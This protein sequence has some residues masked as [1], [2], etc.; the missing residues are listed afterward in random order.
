MKP[1][2]IADV[3][4]FANYAGTM[5]WT[6]GARQRSTIAD[7]AQWLAERAPPLGLSKYSEAAVVLSYAPAPALALGEL[8]D[9]NS[10]T[11]V[12]DLGAGAGGLG[13]TLAILEPSWRVVLADR[14]STAAHFLSLTAQRLSIDNVQVVEAEAHRL[15]RQEGTVYDLVCLRALAAAEI[16][17]GLA[18]PLTRTSGHIAAWHQAK[19]EGFYGPPGEVQRL[20]TAQTVVEGL[21]VSLLRPT[22]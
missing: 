3:E 22:G 11:D 8:I 16:A 20:D 19:D 17:L 5:G 15:A 6:I 13:L 9:R 14:S 21:V 18:E 12:L 2:P 1:P 7:L 10:I 4:H